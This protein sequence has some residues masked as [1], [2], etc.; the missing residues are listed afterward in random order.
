MPF[1]NE[2]IEEVRQICQGAQEMAE[3]GFSYVFLPNLKLPC[4]P[5]CVDGLL[6]PQPHTSY[7]TRLF[8]SAI[9]PGKGVHWTTHTILSRTWHTPSWKDVASNQ[10]PA[11][12][13]AQHLRTYR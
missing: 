6:C 5:G 12:I 2:D 11:E 7:T 3:G 13:L 1:S 4:P 8:L 9:V 10:R